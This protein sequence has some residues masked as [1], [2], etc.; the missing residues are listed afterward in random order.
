MELHVATNGKAGWSGRLAAPNKA[1]TDGPLPGVNA[2]AAGGV[3]VKEIARRARVA[4]STA[5]ET[6]R[7]GGRPGRRF[8]RLPTA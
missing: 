8:G 5:Y 4:S 3:T 2:R 7:G 6:L 1:G